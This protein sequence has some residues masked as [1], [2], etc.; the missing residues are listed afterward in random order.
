MPTA[1]MERH[2]RSHHHQGPALVR[3]HPTLDVGAAVEAV[4]L[5]SEP[6]DESWRPFPYYDERADGRPTLTGLIRSK[7]TIILG[8]RGL[9]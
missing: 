4:R 5:A 6:D 2:R 1:T 9:S 7:V 8:M 3:P